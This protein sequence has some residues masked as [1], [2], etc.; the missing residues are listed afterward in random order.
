[1]GGWGVQLV[2]G[3]KKG[4]RDEREE[5]REE[6]KEVRGKREERENGRVGPMCHIDAKS[7]LNDH[8]NTV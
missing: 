4:K 6:S 7:T 3:E 8:L 1:M 2:R 5:M